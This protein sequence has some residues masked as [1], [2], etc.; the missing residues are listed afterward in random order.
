[1][2]FIL[3]VFYFYTGVSLL[4][5]AVQWCEWTVC[6]HTSPP[7]W[8]SLP[9]P[10]P[11]PACFGHHRALS[12]APWAVPQV[13]TSYLFYTWYYMYVKPN[14]PAHRILHYVHVTMLYVCIFWAY[15]CAG[16]YGYRETHTSSH[17]YSW[18][19]TSGGSWALSGTPSLVT[20]Q[21]SQ[22]SINGLYPGR[23]LISIS[24]KTQLAETSTCLSCDV[25]P[26]ACICVLYFTFPLCCG[27]TVPVLN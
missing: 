10:T 17:S 11:Y 27:W 24:V 6:I 8:V 18:M 2:T 21:F 12:W 3:F 25:H 22:I 14:P 9:F 20:L 1:M 23:A 13:Y 4:Y 16:H 15:T 26:C 5:T 7:S 19:L